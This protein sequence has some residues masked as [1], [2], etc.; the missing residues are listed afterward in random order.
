MS[1]KRDNQ[2]LRR[3][4]TTM[5]DA[6]NEEIKEMSMSINDADNRLQDEIA[7]R[8]LEIEELRKYLADVKIEAETAL[9]NERMESFATG[10]KFQRQQQQAAETNKRAIDL[11]I[12]NLQ[13]NHEKTVEALQLRYTQELESEASEHKKGY[14]NLQ[15][16]RGC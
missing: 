8:D 9:R 4:M 15:F 2:R 5:Q 14:R 6:E 13:E 7:V 1:A 11:A 16:D 12:A 3:E 10:E